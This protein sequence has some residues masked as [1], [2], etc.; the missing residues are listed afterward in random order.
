MT[1]EE[2]WVQPWHCSD[3]IWMGYSY[4]VSNR[5]KKMIAERLPSLEGVLSEYAFLHQVHGNTVLEARSGGKIGQADGLYT[6]EKGLGL[7]IQTADCL[8]VFLIGAN[9]IA[10]VH[11]G[12][13][14]V[15]NQ[16]IEEACQIVQP[17]VAIIGPSISGECYEVGEEVV[18]AIVATGVAEE[19]FVDRS[20]TKA[21]VNCRYAAQHQ[22]LALGV[23]K[24]EV[25]SEC[26]FQD[27]NWASYRRDG[28]D[29]GRILSVIGY[30][31]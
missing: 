23:E 15:A 6:Q 13:R 9:S 3:D 25:S 5:S 30:R 14:G 31:I 28:A 24:I 17:T 21:H 11:A 16:I 29:A 26:T 12:W 19:L 2:E 22:L 7:V 20:K 27:S 18:D 1:K 8:P 10:A 4:G